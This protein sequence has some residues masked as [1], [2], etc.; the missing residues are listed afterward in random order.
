MASPVILKAREEVF[1]NGTLSLNIQLMIKA[2]KV[3]ISTIGATS[4][5]STRDIKPTI[6]AITKKQPIYNTAFSAPVF[7]GSGALAFVTGFMVVSFATFSL[8]EATASMDLRLSFML[9]AIRIANNA[10]TPA[11]NIMTSH[12]YVSIIAKSINIVQISN[13]Q[14][15]LAKLEL[16]R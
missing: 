8:F 16:F 11:T 9:K 7:F 13:P 15:V 3:I 12:F 14:K 6:E 5:S 2:S 4:V 1:R 10:A